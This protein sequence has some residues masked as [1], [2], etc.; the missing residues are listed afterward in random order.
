MPDFEINN[1]NSLTLRTIYDLL[2][3]KKAEEFFIPSYQR[4]YRWNAQ[5]VNLLLQDIW[6][7]A[8]RKISRDLK[9]NEFYCLQPI[10]VKPQLLEG[11]EKWEVIDGQQ[12]L[13]T[14]KLIVR[15]LFTS[16]RT[17]IRE[18]YNREEFIISYDTRTASESFLNDIATLFDQEGE[19]EKN[20]DFHYMSRAYQAIQTWFSKKDREDCRDFISVLL[21]KEDIKNP[22]KIIWYEVRDGSNSYDI[23]TRLNIGKI[24]LTDAELIKALF[25]KRWEKQ[26]DPVLFYAKQL[27]VASDWDRIE[28]SLQNDAFWNFIYNGGHKK[29][30]S[31]RIEY[32]FDLMSGWNRE[33]EDNYTFYHF[34]ALFEE[35]QKKNESA[36]NIE[37]LWANVSAYFLRFDEWFRDRELYHLVGYLVA[38]KVAVP[39]VMAVKTGYEQL[40]FLNKTEFKLALRNE[41]S[42]RLGLTALQLKGLG[43]KS[44]QIL[45]VLLL[46]N[47]QTLLDSVKSNARYPFDLHKS[48]HWDIEHIRSQTERSLTND[49]EWRDWIIDTLEYFTGKP[50][51]EDQLAGLD[52]M[53]LSDETQQ[54]L[55]ML[56]NERTA[57]R[58]Q[59]DVLL[60]CFEFFRK[61]FKEDVEGDGNSIANLALLDSY[62]NR[63]YQNAFYP[64]KRRRIQENERN[65]IFTPI[66]T[67][68]V[69]L[70]AYS[71][72][73]AD[74]MSWNKVD[75]EDYLNEIVRVLNGYLK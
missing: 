41:I 10:V 23:F 45:N 19:R 29:T 17:T 30:Y 6:E 57:Q 67:R 75:G 61:L 43:Y 36:A 62:T 22:V 33:K 4:G 28:R 24:K 53:G 34:N 32:I 31:S 72:K 49:D 46:F 68:N 7:F 20:V 58:F 55:V 25:L 14:I 74:V 15:Y 70:K 42:N 35:S 8:R 59:K 5:Q 48:Q 50:E 54:V 38:T 51:S 39:D 69:F 64:L 63:S 3:E 73:L 56:F 21:A 1:N 37:Q 60:R 18:E 47:I 71:K 44:K 40:E 66:C 65:G 2:T 52:E 9:E 11:K 13:T 16:L 12:R 27:Q 26:G